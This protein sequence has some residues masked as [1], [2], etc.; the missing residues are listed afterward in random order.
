MLQ[1]LPHRRL[2]ILWRVMAAGTALLVSFAVALFLG[3]NPLLYRL[4]TGLWIAAFL[5]LF[6][7][8]QPIKYNKLRYLVGNGQVILQGGVLYR[9]V[10]TMPLENIQFTVV[11]SSPLHLLLGLRTVIL[12]APGGNLFLSGLTPVDAHRLREAIGIP[13]EESSSLE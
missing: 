8:Y 13:P 11:F 1:F 7:I 5:F 3:E 9:K 2:L 4:F 6:V 10:K 12:A